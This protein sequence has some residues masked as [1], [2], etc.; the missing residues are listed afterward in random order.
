MKNIKIFSLAVSL[1]AAGIIYQSCTKDFEEMNTDWKNPTKASIPTVMNS[2]MGSFFLG[3][4]EMQTIHNGYYYLITQQTGNAGPRYVLQQGID[5]I[6]NNYYNRLRNVRYLQKEFESTT[7]VKTDN[8]KAML[9][10]MLAY[11]TLR[12]AD[13]FGDMPFSKAGYAGD[14]TEFKRPVYDKHEDIY[15]E[16]L[17]MLK[18]AA[19]SF[20]DGASDQVEGIGDAYNIFWSG[21][22]VSGKSY[23]MWRKLANSIRLRYAIQLAD[24]DAATANAHIA[25]I[26]GNPTTYPLLDGDGRDE[27]AGMWIKK[28]SYSL[29]S[30]PWTFSANNYC[31][32]GSTMWSEMTDLAVPPITEATKTS[33]GVADPQ[34]YDPRGYLFFET[35]NANLWIPQQQI[36]ANPKQAPSACYSN[37]AYPDG[38]YYG[39]TQQEW[40]NKKEGAYYSNVNFYLATDMES[41]PE[42]IMTE[43]EVHFL[44][45]EAYNRGLGISKN[46]AKAKE[47]YEAGIRASMETWFSFVGLINAGTYKWM[48]QQ[49]AIPSAADVTAYINRANI[50]YSSDEATALKQIYK[51]VWIDSFRQPWVAFNLYCRSGATPHA[52]GDTQEYAKFRR[53][54]YPP[55]EETYNTQNFSNALNGNA[56]D[57]KR[58]L[59]WHRF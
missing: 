21:S 17:D 59:F 14:G 1:L 18:S 24:I 43:A 7:S 12:T 38:R 27:T 29:E 20:V 32:M 53:V 50:V 15:K 25:E 8:V 46:S 52:S 4:Q 13:Y 56:N 54:P 30:R 45:A 19:T 23:L 37:V 9:D 41:T 26:L 33:A 10:V 36:D 2:V 16:C 3:W 34:F 5:D 49:P 40:S 48:I 44:K 39:Q 31:C 6:W 22:Y 58:K 47:S 28:L 35:N 51:Q 42:L 55:S 11:Q 57:F